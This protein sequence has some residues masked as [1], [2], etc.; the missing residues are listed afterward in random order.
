[1]RCPN[2]FQDVLP[3]GGMVRPH[4][5]V[6]SAMF[7]GLP[8]ITLVSPAMPRGGI[9]PNRI[10]ERIFAEEKVRNCNV[11]LINS[12]MGSNEVIVPGNSAHFRRAILFMDA[13]AH[14]LVKAY[15]LIK[16]LSSGSRCFLI[17]AVFCE[18]E[19]SNPVLQ[20]VTKLQKTIFKHLLMD[21]ELRVVPVPLDREAKISMQS[22]KPLALMESSTP[23]SSARAIA[24]LCK[25]LL[26]SE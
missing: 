12:P 8:E 24:K 7:Y 20:N 14:A 19:D 11:I 10:V 17:G 26:R 16:R 25:N 5:K 13:R 22:G 3:S 9:L 4:Y 21:L 1:M 2:G 6:E 15:S 18:G 23:S